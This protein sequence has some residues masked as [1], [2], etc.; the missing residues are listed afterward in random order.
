MIFVK[1]A[2]FLTSA[3]KLVECPPPDVIE[4]V[5]LGRS[6]VGKSTFINILLDKKLAKSSATPGKTRLINF[7]TSVW[8]R[9]GEI[10]ESISLRLVDLPGFGY[11]KVS[12]EVKREWESY[13]WDFLHRRNCIKLFIHLIDSRHTGLEIDT[14]VDEVLYSIIKGDQKILNIYT[15][16]DKLNKNE[17][18]FFYRQNRVVVS[19]NDKIIDKR[20]GGKDKVRELILNT[21]LGFGMN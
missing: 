10:C 2:N 6:N 14:Y 13:L 1:E 4:I 15:K 12:K 18:Y 16:F 7:F 11:A 3:K 5:F 9:K 8:E 21:A 20:Y 17:Q 19:N